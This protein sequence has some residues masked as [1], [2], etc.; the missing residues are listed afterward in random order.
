MK[1][2]LFSCLARCQVP[3]IASASIAVAIILSDQGDKKREQIRQ[4]SSGFFG[5]S[6]KP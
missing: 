6:S 2:C 4:K 3:E 1:R 5:I